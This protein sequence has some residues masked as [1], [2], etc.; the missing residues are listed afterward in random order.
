MGQKIIIDPLG[1]FEVMIPRS[2]TVVRI[3]ASLE[4]LD[5]RIFT[6][7]T[8]LDSGIDGRPLHETKCLIDSP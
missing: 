1:R 7:I 6:C 8:F 5:I 2:G 4:Q 3:C